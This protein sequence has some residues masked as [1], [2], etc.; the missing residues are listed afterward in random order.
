MKGEQTIRKSTYTNDC[1]E[2]WN[3]CSKWV[4]VNSKLE[5][6]HQI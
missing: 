5:T 6:L 2:I 4:V 1:F 3:A